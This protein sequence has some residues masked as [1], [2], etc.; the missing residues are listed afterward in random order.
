MLA[1]MEKVF[2]PSF[3][4][5]CYKYGADLTFTELIRFETLAKNNKSALK[6]IVLHY[7]TPTMIQFMGKNE[8][9]LDHFLSRYEV[10]NIGFRGFNFNLGCPS[11][12]YVNQG[13]GCAMVKRPTKMKRMVDIVRDHGFPVSVKIRLGMNKGEKLEKIYLKLIEKVDADFFVVHAR[14]RSQSYEEKPDWSVFPECVATGKSIIANGDISTKEDVDLMKEMGCQGVMIGRAAIINPLIFG[15]LKGMK[16]P[17][18][19]KVFDEYK[20]LCEG[21]ELND[22]DYALSW[23]A[24]DFKYLKG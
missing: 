11:K 13:V 10:D 1:P 24:D 14:Y 22:S 17:N 21:Q 3:R 19:S 2:D 20:Q 18:L 6:R 12:N 5:I 16:I 7:D 4:H 9:V 8:E 23:T 15:E